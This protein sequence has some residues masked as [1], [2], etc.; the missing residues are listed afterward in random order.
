MYCFPSLQLNFNQYLIAVNFAVVR[1]QSPKPSSSSPHFPSPE[2]VPVVCMYVS[3]LFMWF[4]GLYVVQL[5]SALEN[6]NKLQFDIPGSSETT[7]SRP[8]KPVRKTSSK[9]V[10]R[11]IEEVGCRGLC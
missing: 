6:I 8:V 11:E 9:P 1:Q 2:Q 3:Y 10:A 7:P 4:C 5:M